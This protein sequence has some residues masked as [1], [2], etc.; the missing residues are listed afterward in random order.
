MSDVTTDLMKKIA[1]D[2][3]NAI[4]RTCDLAATIDGP[5]LP[6]LMAA[7]AAALGMLSG[8]LERMGGTQR[9]DATGPEYQVI[10]LAG[11]LA[12]RHGM[13][14]PDPTGEAYRDMEALDRV[15]RVPQGTSG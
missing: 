14:L 1:D 10:L 15:G 6:L 8:E 7:A 5:R 9:P 2:V 3:G 11:L 13:Q 12:A 4:L